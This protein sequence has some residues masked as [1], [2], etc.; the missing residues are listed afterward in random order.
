[1][2]NKSKMQTALNGLASAHN[3]A[4][5]YRSIISDYSKQEFGCDPAEVDNDE[6]ID[7]NDGGCGE[8]TPMSVDEF[9]ASMTKRLQ[10]DTPYCR[11]CVGLCGNDKHGS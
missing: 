5:K 3:R 4:R 9:R 8:C 10:V 1:M 7:Q 2:I 6:F 11:L